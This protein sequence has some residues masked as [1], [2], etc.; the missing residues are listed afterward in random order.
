MSAL[1][2][3]RGYTGRDIIVKFDGGYHGH[4]DGLLVKA[5][6]GAAT[7][8]APDSAG[9]PASVAQNTLVLRYNDVPA[10]QACFASMPEQIAAV[11]VEPVAGNMGC[12]PPA[13]GFLSAIVEL[14]ARYGAVSIFDEVMTGCR[15]S[16][17]GAQQLYGLKPALSCLGKII[18]GGMPLAVYGGRREIMQRISPLGPV[19]QAG[20]L[21]GSP[22]AVAAGLATLAQLTPELYRH[23]ELLGA[24]LEQGLNAALMATQTD[25]CV[26]RVGSMITL[27][28]RGGPI[29]SWD[30]ARSAD[31]ARFG[32]W[33]SALLAGGVYWPPAQFEAA[34]ISGKHTTS[35]IDRTIEVAEQALRASV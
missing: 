28:F 6:S 18:G 2:V 17:G 27:F 12:V 19:Y 23:L 10:L 35:D 14:C 33:H 16:E 22:L 4:S 9:V 11:I 1:R 7:F 29:V 8:G 34:F 32:R 24:R 31:T 13:P 5:G 20:T 21:S 3:A 25:G 26:Q 15:L 30:D